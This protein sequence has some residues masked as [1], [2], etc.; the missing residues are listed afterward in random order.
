VVGERGGHASHGAELEREVDLA[1][2]LAL[3]LLD[4]LD[5]AV[6]HV[7]EPALGDLGERGMISMSDS[8]VFSTPGT[9]DLEDDLVPSSSTAR[10]ACAMEAAANDSN[11]TSEKCSSSRP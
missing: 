8:S 9:E 5:G 11:S 4:D 7:L 10:W 3:E 6:A 2:D 1:P